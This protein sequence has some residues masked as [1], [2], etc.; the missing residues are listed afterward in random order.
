MNSQV[1]QDY[2]AMRNEKD[3]KEEGAIER[4]EY[5]SLKKYI[6]NKL[7]KSLVLDDKKVEI[8]EKNNEITFADVA[9]A[10]VRK[11]ASLTGVDAILNRENKTDD[12]YLAV[13]NKFEITR[14]SKK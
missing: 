4:E 13:G 9:N 10:G 2:M 6:F 14:K 11:L 8:T 5:I 1:I 7:A 3:K 12:F